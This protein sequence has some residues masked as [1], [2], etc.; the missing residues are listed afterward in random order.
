MTLWSPS[1]TSPRF[2]HTHRSP[3]S[4]VCFSPRTFR[5]ASTQ[6]LPVRVQVEYLLVGNEAGQI[7]LYSVEWPDE[8]NMDLFA[9]PGS[10]TVLARLD[11]HT[12][13]IC[14]LAWSPDGRF[15]ASGGN[16]NALNIFETRR[17]LQPENT[18]A[19]HTVMV[20]DDFTYY[21]PS[22][23]EEALW[24]LPGRQSHHYTLNAAVKALAFCPWQPSLLAAGGGSNDRCIHFYHTISGAKLATIDCSS[25]V[26]SLVWSRTRREIAATFGFT[27]PDHPIR[28]AVFSWPACECTVRI[29]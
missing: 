18:M 22:G 2:N 21:P 9:W 11:L 26:T 27:Q 15:F 6:S 23:Q 29:P 16:D 13:Q 19:H 4:C 8:L 10:M 12:Q 1:E 14:G 5:R 17:I 3:I 20:R 24:V 7:Y 28:V 25:Q